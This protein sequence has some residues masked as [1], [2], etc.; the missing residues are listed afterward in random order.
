[1]PST[2]PTLT[3]QMTNT[4]IPANN[5]ALQDVVDTIALCIGDVTRWEVKSSAAGYVE[6]GPVAAS[7]TPNFRV[8]VAFG[9]NNAQMASPHSNN[10]DCLMIGFAPDG[11]TLGSPLGAAAPYGA[12]RWSGYWRATGL[13]TSDATEQVD[14]CFCIGSDEVI[15]I[16]FGDSGSENWFGLI[17]GAMF[18]PPTDA[19][20]EGTPGRVYGMIVNGSAAAIPNAFWNNVAH[21]TGH[22][23]G[24]DDP[25][26]GA[27]NP[28]APANFVALERMSYLAPAPPRFETAGGTMVSLPVGYFHNGAPDNFV[29]ILRQMRLTNDGMMRQIIQD[30]TP[31][32]QSYRVS[33]DR[34]SNEDVLS[35]DNG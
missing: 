26:V 1:M 14:L 28:A 7:A 10:S 30:S 8:L 11:G 24:A 19:D 21:F 15:S 20:G 25:S 6:L 4:R 16:W 2:A 5:N 12:A 32:D 22:N 34:F 9:V 3:W 18:D 13:I 33:G 35:F 23:G 31:A 17:T 27:F 29:G